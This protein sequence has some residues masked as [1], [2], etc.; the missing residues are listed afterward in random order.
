MAFDWYAGDDGDEVSTTLE[1][2]GWPELSVLSLTPDDDRQAT[3][4]ERMSEYEVT[5]G[6]FAREKLASP[7]DGRVTFS[8]DEMKR[9]VEELEHRG[10]RP[11]PSMLMSEAQLEAARYFV[12]K[13]QA[14]RL[15][16][17]R[18][19]VRDYSRYEAA[20]KAALRRG[21]EEADAAWDEVDPSNPEDDELDALM[22][23]Y[24]PG[25]LD[26]PPEDDDED[27]EEED[28]I[29]TETIWASARLENVILIEAP[30]GRP[31]IF[32]LSGTCDWEEE[33][34]L[35]VRFE[36]LEV[37]EVGYADVARG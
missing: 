15:A 13:H 28:P 30:A 29:D 10:E 19:L 25:L 18:A 3:Y 21:R 11:D 9:A 26:E 12:E 33:H 5:L 24:D 36:G 2:P 17:A 16:A 23:G 35:G 1:L 7:E 20:R 34:G 4:R 6:P 14:F 8:M 31:P 32:G 22:S 37:V 27:E